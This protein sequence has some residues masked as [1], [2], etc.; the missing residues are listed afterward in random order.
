MKLKKEPDWFSIFNLEDTHHEPITSGQK[1]EKE[2]LEYLYLLLYAVV[3]WRLIK[4]LK[5]FESLL[6]TTSSLQ[7]WPNTWDSQLIYLFTLSFIKNFW[8]LKH[9]SH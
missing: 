3:E 6:K 9:I 1:E 8:V 2:F 7:Q 5:M 4:E